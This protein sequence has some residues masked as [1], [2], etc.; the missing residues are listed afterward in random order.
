MG[1]TFAVGFDFRCDMVH[2]NAV[3]CLCLGGGALG[4]A[5]HRLVGR[6]QAWALWLCT[7]LNAPKNRIHA[8]LLQGSPADPWMGLAGGVA[9]FRLVVLG[10][11]FAEG[12]ALLLAIGFR[13]VLRD[14]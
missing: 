14:G 8:R 12:G 1:A 10:A 3:A 2:R 4:R 5:V 7:L 9:S 6:G 11:G 13:K